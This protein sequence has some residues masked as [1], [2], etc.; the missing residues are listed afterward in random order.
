MDIFGMHISDKIYMPI[1]IIVLFLLV[2]LLI[3]GILNSKR[4]TNK[5][6]SKH[7]QRSRETVLLLIKHIIRVV[8]VII[9]ILAILQV[10]GVDTTVLVT[11]IGAVTVIIGL[12]FQDVLKDLLVGAAI[13][14]ESQY[15]IGEMVEINGFKGEVVSLNL[16][17]TRLKSL[18][19]ETRIIS[20]RTISQV[21]NYSLDTILLKIIVSVSYEDDI[22][23]VEKVLSEVT[24][25]LN[26][27][28]DEL[29]SEI[30]IQ[31]VESLSSSSVD[32]LL[33]MRV[34]EKEQYGV[35]RR[36]LKEIKLAFDKN[37][38]KIP[39]KQVEVHNGK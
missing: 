20:N 4:T 30:T 38:I 25:R 39:Y 2:D 33:T 3:S 1:I 23:K 26:K 9:A 32:F 22:D 37:N 5:K 13:I 27:E 7:A 11:S 19:G 14:M 10:F 16:R 21:T 31:G 34:I 8:L 35:R 15:A 24:K 17:S 28:I 12:A 29:K 18:T 6:L 36:V